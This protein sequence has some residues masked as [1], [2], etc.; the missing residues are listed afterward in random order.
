[1]KR[2]FVSIASSYVGFCVATVLRR[3][4]Y[5]VVGS[6]RTEGE[7]FVIVSKFEYPNSNVKNF[8]STY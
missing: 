4:G 7:S 2:A 3:R 1:M 5:D 6:C 8:T